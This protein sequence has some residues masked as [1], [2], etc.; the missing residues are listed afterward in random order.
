MQH[1]AFSLRPTPVRRNLRALCLLAVAG[2]AGVASGAAQS[3]YKVTEIGVLPGHNHGFA[4]SINDAGQVAGYSEANIPNMTQRGWVYKA[5]TL[6]ALGT[7]P[8]RG[9]YSTATFIHPTTGVIVGDGDTGDFRPQGMVRIGAN[10]YNVFPNHGG[11]THVLRIDTAGR[12]YGYFI[13]GKSADWM[14]GMWTPNPKKAGT[15]TQTILG[16]PGMPLSFN[17]NGQGVG[18]QSGGT[19]RQLAAFWDNTG[20]RAMQFL[21]FRPEFSSSSANALSDDGTTIVGTGHPAF[22]SLPLLWA[23]T[24]TTWTLR[25]LPVLTGDNQGSAN[26]V[27]NAGV[28]IGTSTYGIPGTWQ[29]EA[30]T[31]VVW[32]QGVPRE[33]QPLLDPVT[34]AGWLITGLVGINNSGQIAAN[35]LKGGF[36]RAIILTPVP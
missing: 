4:I 29:I 36:S 9:Q 12:I 14:G 10:L 7:L 34:G 13:G 21:P 26:G 28:V 22:S 19:A 20:A 25:D 31:S 27:N 33:I 17:A 23:R 35:A 24:G 3:A 15:Y 11:N 1:P 5:G 8:K 30:S 32:L 16:G 2:I 6:A 18:Y